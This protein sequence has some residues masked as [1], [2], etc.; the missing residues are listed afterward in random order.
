[1]YLLQ[2]YGKDVPIKV[3][4]QLVNAFGELRLKADIGQLNYPYST[5][6]VVNIVKHLQVIMIYMF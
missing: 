1:M 4:E 3:I 2:Q 5:R 6:E